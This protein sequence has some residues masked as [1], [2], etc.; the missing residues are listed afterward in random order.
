[1]CDDRP[2]SSLGHCR[3]VCEVHF[4]SVNANVVGSQAIKGAIS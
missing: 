2:R 4:Y 3:Q 1:M